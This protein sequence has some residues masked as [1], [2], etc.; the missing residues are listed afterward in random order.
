MTLKLNSLI[1]LLVVSLSAMSQEN[2]PKPGDFMFPIRP[3]QEN[4]LSGT[5]GELRRTHFHTGLDIKTSGI[6]GLPVYATADGYV[7]RIRVSTSGYGNA[8]YLSHPHNNTVSVYAHLEAFSPAIAKY[9]REKQ[10]ANESFEV[11]LFPEKDAF[12]FKKGDII[13]K[14][15]NSGSSSG[16][17]LHFEIRTKNHRAI[18]PLRFGFDEIKDTSPPILDKV[19][20]V[21]KDINSR[22]NGE[23]GRHEFNVVKGAS[24]RMELDNPVYLEGKIG[25]EIYA[26]DRF[27]RA[28]NRNGIF[29]ESLLL[30]KKV[31][32]SQSVDSLRFNMA[33]S[34][35]VHTNYKRSVE[36]GRRF[37]KL[38]IDHGNDLHFY[39]ANRESGVLCFND[40]L[41]HEIEIRLADSYGN[42]SQ[43]LIEVNT[44]EV[45]E[46]ATKVSYNLPQNGFD[47]LE[48]IL[49]I[50]TDLSYHGYC[51]A[52]FFKSG[53]MTKVQMAYD[54][55]DIGYYLYDLRKGLPDSVLVCDEHFS[56][57]FAKVIP[58]NTTTSWSNSTVD[59]TFPRGSLFDTT[60]LRYR[61][62]GDAQAEY[63]EFDNI[64]TPMKRNF[65][66]TLHPRKSYDKEKS[67]VYAVDA[68]SN[69]SF[70]G[71]EWRD[72]SILFE[73]RD[74]MKYTI[75]TDTVPP[76]IEVRKSGAGRLRMRI[77]DEM[78]GIKDYRAELN[79]K[80]L[81]MHYDA[82]SNTIWSD[83]EITVKG[84][85]KITVT[86]NSEN[87][88]VLERT[89]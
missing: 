42:I 34:I 21:T 57:D 12:V 49:E 45:S 78:S 72:G 32:F 68:S 10:Y 19:A 29:A 62:S 16:P 4:Y 61:Y 88:T 5:M 71:G 25:V 87:V 50:K 56:F 59:I 39:A 23:F 80:W 26:Y 83:P 17:H 36:G 60:Y 54:K 13:A 46:A 11:N 6:T 8:L 89:Y 82:K 15:G 84:E 79:G 48:N 77:R 65:S 70:I 51:E 85:F 3:K 38:Y 30:D 76:I 2:E 41:P 27:D 14:S 74:L 20:F 73:A 58:A 43:Y 63:F 33:K 67:L 22:V 40:P 81:L 66:A 53:Q 18:D 7:Q 35:L 44:H 75:A 69:L 24:G 37:N 1:F 64:T 47:I 9:V 52:L 55:H 28:R 31:V 86:D